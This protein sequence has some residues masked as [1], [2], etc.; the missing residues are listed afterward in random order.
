M[1][2]DISNWIRGN[3]GKLTGRLKQFDNR[4]PIGSVL[5]MAAYSGLP[6]LTRDR[7]LLI[8]YFLGKGV[9]PNVNRERL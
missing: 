3:G 2:T 6:A 4:Y 9:N 1:N 5:R 7:S 8:V